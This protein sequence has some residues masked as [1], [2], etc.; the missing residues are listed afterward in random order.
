MMEELTEKQK[1]LIHLNE[2]KNILNNCTSLDD[3]LIGIYQNFNAITY[4][5]IFKP[6]MDSSNTVT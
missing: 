1:L 4:E 6:L 3:E 5:D 2:V